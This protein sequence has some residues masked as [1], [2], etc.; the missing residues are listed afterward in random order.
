MLSDDI[1]ADLLGP[2]PQIRPDSPRIR[3][4]KKPAVASDSPNSPDS[5]LMQPETQSP[6]GLSR[7][8]RIWV[9]GFEIDFISGTPMS[10]AEVEAEYP[11]ALDVQPRIP[12]GPTMQDQPAFSENAKVVCCQNCQKFEP[13]TSPAAIGR[14][15]VNA[16]SSQQRPCWAFARRDCEQFEETQP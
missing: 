15:R 5:P 4:A 12:A 13:G 1:V 6:A 10:R 8:W 3:P 16:P 7:V 14:C 11:N 2:S 9:K